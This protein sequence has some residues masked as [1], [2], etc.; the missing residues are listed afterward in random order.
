MNLKCVNGV[1]ILTCKD[2]CNYILQLDLYLMKGQAMVYYIVMKLTI[3]SRLYSLY[4][5]LAIRMN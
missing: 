5:A 4:A 1:R 2:Q 3:D